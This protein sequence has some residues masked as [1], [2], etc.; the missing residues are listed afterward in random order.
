MR[1]IQTVH[2]VLK[3]AVMTGVILLA[4]FAARRTDACSCTEGGTSCNTWANATLVLEGTVASIKVFALEN[5]ITLENVKAWRG[6]P[7]TTIVTKTS[8]GSCGY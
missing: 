6:R 3:S 1:E 5:V 4:L 2:R 7:Q 8:S